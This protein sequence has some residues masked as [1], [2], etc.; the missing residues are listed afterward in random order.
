MKLK[1]LLYA[2]VG[3]AALAFSTASCSDYLDISGEFNASLG[4]D[5]VWSNAS[6]TRNWYGVIYRHLMEYSETGSE[7]SAF[8]NPW[9]NLCGEIASEKASSRD[10]MMAGFT[11]ASGNY[12]RWA[13]FYKDVRQAMIFIE[14][15]QDQGVGDPT[16]TD[17]LT[18][19]EIAR[20]K[21]EC[22]F[23]IAYYYF[24]MFELYGPACIVTEIDDAAEPH[25]TD[26]DRATVD[27]MVNHIDGILAPLCDPAQSKLPESVITSYA[28]NTYNFNTNEVVRPTS[29]VLWPLR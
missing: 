1:N 17:K 11:A 16:S 9:S 29:V 8:K 21:D 19:E 10:V 23:M 15:A 13:N 3:S 26:Y 6:Y 24:S 5:E 7:V 20:M 28:D 22:R 27:E 2:A 25:I 18:A 4:V 12:H 14:R